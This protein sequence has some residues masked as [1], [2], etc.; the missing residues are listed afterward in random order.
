MGLPASL[1][2]KVTFSNVPVVFYIENIHQDF[3]DEP[4]FTR[5]ERSRLD[6]EL[7]LYKQDMEVH[8]ESQGNTR[9]HFEGDKKV[10]KAKLIQHL[11]KYRLQHL[12]EE[13]AQQRHNEKDETKVEN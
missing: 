4:N 1:K 2:R 12:Q 9:F 3:A 8:A 13:R 5:Q 6:D 7:N 11:F 10:R